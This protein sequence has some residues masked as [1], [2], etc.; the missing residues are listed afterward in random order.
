MLFHTRRNKGDVCALI[1]RVWLL[2]GD[3]HLGSLWA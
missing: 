1:L 3:G 2:L